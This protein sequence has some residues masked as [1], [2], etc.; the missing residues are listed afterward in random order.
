MKKPKKPVL[1]K[2]KVRTKFS[3]EDFTKENL[4][5]GA[6]IRPGILTLSFLTFVGGLVLFIEALQGSLE[7]M[8]WAGS[9][10][11]FS[12]ILT[13][14]SIYTSLRDEHSV[15]RT[16]NVG[17]KVVLFVFE[18]SIFHQTILLII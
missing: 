10:L 14:Q 16:Y 12:F 7:A 9:L 1:H 2:E 8:K 4:I 17:F 11:I 5:K 6:F 3:K 15:F 18:I 13:A